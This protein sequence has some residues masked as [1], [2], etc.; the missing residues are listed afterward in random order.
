MNLINFFKNAIH[1]FL[2]SWKN[3]CKCNKKE[4]EELKKIYKEKNKN[5][6]LY[7]NL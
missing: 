1:I 3:S 5:E 7:K 2:N 6:N 4:I